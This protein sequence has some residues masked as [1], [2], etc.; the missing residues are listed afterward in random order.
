MR[1]FAETAER[2]AA[3]GSKLEKVRLLAEYLQS[4]DE[5]R[6]GV[7]ARFFSGLVFPTWDMRVLSLGGAALWGVLQSLSGATAEEMSAAWARHGDAGGVA[8]DVLVRAL[9]SSPGVD[10]LDVAHTF[11][12]IA[13]APSAAERAALL[14]TLLR[15]ST[16]LEAKYV[17]KLITGEMRIGLREGL[18]EEAIAV[19][20]GRTKAA[21]SRADMV[22][23]DLG[24]VALLARQDRLDTAAPRLFAPMRF[25]LA[26]PVADAD[27]VVARMG[28][29]VWIEDK[30]DGI[31]CQVHRDDSRVML[32]SRDLKDVTAQFPEVAEV[33]AALP[34]IM[35][36]DG[37]ILAFRDGTVMPFA[38]LQTRLGRKKPTLAVLD[39]VP[40]IFVAW[41]VLY[42]DGESLLD[43]PLRERRKRLDALQLGG[44]LATAHQEHARGAAAV[45]L[46]FD[47]ARARLNEGLIAKDPSSPY[48]PGRRGL[49]WL[50][51]K[52]PLDTLDVVVTGAEL[53]HGKRRDVL[54]DVTFSV[55]VDESDELVP[56]GK[57]Y[58]GLTDAEILE[59]TSLLKAITVS[60][61]GRFRV[62][63]PEI[64]LEV[65]FDRV[66][67]SSRH[68][69][70]YALRFPRIARWRHDKPVAEIDTLSRVA[71]LAQTRDGGRVQLVDRA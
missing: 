27:E 7:A 26:S 2:I 56:I 11:E 5:T 32:F 29:E 48:T 6:V 63:R 15:S 67:P 19:A 14:D 20:F 18:V 45:D 31:R 28:E 8:H 35:L 61:H 23:G 37:E 55:R 47:S 25:M 39:A 68:R 4:L 38:A 24:E 30:Y 9:G 40:V 13:S 71:A 22:I 62:V 33:V 64:V 70:G 66:Q 43:E 69:S 44:A 46:L 59:M 60:E 1:R 57:A 16:P 41:D 53:G 49:S 65:A 3:T 50:K 17:V 21:V 42:L 10:L 54:S 36:L 51:L 58:T 34:G 12:R 52:K